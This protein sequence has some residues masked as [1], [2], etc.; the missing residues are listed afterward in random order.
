MREMGRHDMTEDDRYIRLV[1]DQIAAMTGDF[2]SFANVVTDAL[3][4]NPVPFLTFFLTHQYGGRFGDS[5][6]FESV[7][8]LRSVLNASLQ[9]MAANSAA[10]EFECLTSV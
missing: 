5:D 4:R 2:D 9:T 1:E 10:V 3:E 8:S 7:E 6:R